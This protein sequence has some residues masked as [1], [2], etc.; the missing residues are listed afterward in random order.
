MVCE[1][2]NSHGI[3]AEHVDAKSKPKHREDTIKKLE[4]G[5]I[6]VITN[7]NLFSVGV[8]IPCLDCVIHARPTKSY[9][10]WIQSNGRCTRPFPNKKDFLI[11]D[12]VGNI[13]EHGLIEVEREIL[14]EG[15]KT[16]Q[17]NGD[18]IIN[19]ENCYACFSPIEQFKM[20]FKS[21]FFEV[22]EKF[23]EFYNNKYTDKKLG[24]RYFKNKRIYFC[25]ECDFDN[26]PE[27]EPIIKR[28]DKTEDILKILTEEEKH[29]LKCK[30]R[31]LELKKIKKVKEYKRG[32]VYFTL[33]AEFGE[34]LANKF[35]KKIVVP[36]FIKRKLQT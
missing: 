10:F 28:T 15:W 24:D 34:E 8:D 1:Y 7:V 32:W 5:E 36:D 25:P 31:H 21:V 4:S 16:E 17:E 14:L 9:N 11:L 6:K 22:I 23:C 3:P 2:F 27:S 18:V 30:I 19:C 29:L 26:T 12:H 13:A 20:I 33:K 35:C